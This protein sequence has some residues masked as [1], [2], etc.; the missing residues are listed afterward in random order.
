[1]DLSIG[2]STFFKCWSYKSSKSCMATFL[3]IGLPEQHYNVIIRRFIKHCSCLFISLFILLDLRLQAKR[4]L[5]KA[6]L[7]ASCSVS[8]NHFFSKTADRIFMKFYI[9]FWFPKDTKVIQPGKYI[10]S[11]KKPEI[12]LIVGLFGVDKRLFSIDMQFLGLRDAPQLSL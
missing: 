5:M 12:S 4:D 6:P 1:M 7:S 2:V 9:S 8:Q 10:I 3:G 11:Q